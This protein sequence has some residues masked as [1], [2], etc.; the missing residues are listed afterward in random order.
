[1]QC[2]LLS[3]VQAK[4]SSTSELAQNCN[5]IVTTTPSITPLLLAKDIQPGTQITAMGSDTSEKQELEAEILNK[6]DI[7]I[8]DSI[9][10]SKSRG[11]I[12][13]AVKAGSIDPQKVVEL[14]HAIQDSKLQRTDNNQITVVD[15][16]GVAVQD[17]MITEAVYEAH[18]QSL[19]SQS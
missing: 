2:F 16:T 4:A 7:V 12:Y 5:L 13:Q 19:N 10:Q 6:A 15:L 9:P 3:R 17:I 18:L 1:M 14:G 11:E 8:A